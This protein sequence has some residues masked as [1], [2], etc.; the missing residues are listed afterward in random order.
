[1]GKILCVAE[2]PSAGADIARVLGCK[3][4]KDGYIEGDKYIVTWSIG[5][6]VGLKQPDEVDEKYKKW[7]LDG[8]PFCFDYYDSLKILPDTKKQYNVI[9]SLIHR[10]DVDTLVN[11]GDA[12]REGMLIQELI[13][14]MAKNNKPK[15]VL[16]ANSL[17]DEAILKAFNNLHEMSEFDGLYEEARARQWGDYAVGMSYTR[18]LSI[19]LG[20]GKALRYGRCQ[21]PLLA[22][23]AKREDEI[24]NFKPT[25]Y[26]ELNS[27]YESGFTGTLLGT[28]GV[29]QFENKSAAQDIIDD[30]TGKSGIIKTFKCEDKQTMAPTLFSLSDLQIAIGKKYKFSPDKTLNIAQIL[31]E[32]YK[33]I[34]YPRTDSN[35]IPTDVWNEIQGHIDSVTNIPEFNSFKSLTP[36]KQNKKYVN[37]GKVTDH[38][39]IIPTID[40]KMASAVGEMTEDEKNVFMEICK[41]F[42]AIFLPVYT[43][44]STEI[45]VEV[46]DKQFKSSGNVPVEQG[47]RV[48]Y[49][50]Q[51]EKEDEGCELPLLTEGESVNIKELIVLD[52]ITKAPSR[53]NVSSVI[54]LEKAHSIGTSATM[55]TFPQ[56]LQKAGYIKL[57]KG[58][59]YVTDLGM[60]Y[61]KVIPDE[62]KAD[63]LTKQFEDRLDS[64]NNSSLSFEEFQEQLKTE[65]SEMIEKFK[66]LNK[67]KDDDS[68]KPLCPKCGK[69]ILE[70][71]KAYSCSGWKT[72]C[73]FTI[74]KTVAGKKLT[75]KHVNDLITKG[76]TSKIKGF[77]KKAGGT[78][79]AYLVMKEDGSV[80]FEFK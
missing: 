36:T 14:H 59:Y 32:K 72:G 2:K 37:N 18:A 73:K 71:S 39:A 24:A 78:F 52:K 26:Y 21:T 35:V 45:I 29:L 4:R 54:Q 17:T 60:E 70:N 6:L 66:T 16:W 46:G 12:G 19:I 63:N 34:T 9:K 23:L 76:K 67:I 13:Y 49:K 77:T 44:K 1:M 64:V 41:R 30:L 7:T 38:H 50:N 33:V 74:W 28:D 43:Y 61:I 5:H 68:N 57:E 31:Y 15:K 3:Q 79:D 20:N 48:L 62:L 25:S 40:K 80:G 58:K 55:A 22:L 11:C 75:D 53:Y 10:K 51:K 47:W 65:Q 27:V 69:P 56:K 42:L 8:L